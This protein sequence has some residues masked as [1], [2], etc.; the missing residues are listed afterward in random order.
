MILGKLL[1]Y[2]QWGLANRV[3]KWKMLKPIL[4]TFWIV[5]IGVSRSFHTY[6]HLLQLIG[7]CMW[8]EGTAH[9][10]LRAVPSL[11]IY[12]H[13]TFTN[14]EFLNYLY[15]THFLAPISAISLLVLYYFSINCIVLLL[16]IH[17]LHCTAVICWLEW[18]KLTTLPSQILHIVPGPL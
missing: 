9:S 8:T 2:F 17:E 6:A 12:I 18:G 16:H 3:S 15:M 14:A 10:I 5:L 4:A 1:M 13:F 7:R 11:Y